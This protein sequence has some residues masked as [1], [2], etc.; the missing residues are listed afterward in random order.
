MWTKNAIRTIA[1]LG[2]LIGHQATAL[3]ID[4]PSEPIPVGPAVLDYSRSV[5]VPRVTAPGT[6]VITERVRNVGGASANNVVITQTLPTGWTV[7][8]SSTLRVS[9]DTIAVGQTAT[10]ASTVSISAASSVGRFPNE[11]MLT[12]T[13]L[14]TLEATVPIDVTKP[15]VLGATTLPETGSPLAMLF[16]MGGAAI[17][18]IGVT[19]RRT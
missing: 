3:G 1:L 19:L 4:P 12:A 11:A 13:G 18:G 14:D 7:D 16:V 2:L 6:F 17:T 15:A 8:G 5:S 9:F 10:H